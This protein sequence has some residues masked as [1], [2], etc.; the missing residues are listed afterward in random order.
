MKNI[1]QLVKNS[2]MLSVLHDLLFRCLYSSSQ[3]EVNLIP[4]YGELEGG[5]VRKG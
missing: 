1:V 3:G 2:N 4:H 5:W